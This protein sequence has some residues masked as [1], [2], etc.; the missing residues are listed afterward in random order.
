MSY[1]IVQVAEFYGPKTVSAPLVDERNKVLQFATRAEAEAYAAKCRAADYAA[2]G[3]PELE[4][5]QASAWAY[6]VRRV[7]S[8]AKTWRGA[9]L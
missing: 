8:R 6:L 9:W 4:H 1:A 3:C 2:Y 7:R 5:G